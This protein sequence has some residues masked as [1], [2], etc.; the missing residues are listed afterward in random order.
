MLNDDY[1]NS[2]Q[3]RITHLIQLTKTTYEELN[4]ISSPSSY[5]YN[6]KIDELAELIFRIMF[7]KKQLFRIVNA[8]EELEHMPTRE[9]HTKIR[10]QRL[11]TDKAM[12]EEQI[13]IIDS[14]I[15]E[16]GDDKRFDRLI[17]KL[18]MEKFHNQTSLAGV[19]SNLRI[20]EQKPDLT[21]GEIDI[22]LQETEGDITF[23]GIIYLHNTSIDVGTIEYRGDCETKWLG[24]IGYTIS[25]P[26]KGNNYA[27]KALELISPVIASKGVEKVTITVKKHNI[28]SIKTIEKFGGILTNTIDDDVLSYTCEIKPILENKITKR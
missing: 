17:N 25:E 22:Y 14:A 9:E 5:E 15:Q 27:F 4:T 12:F 10:H 2:L 21:D 11:L 3:D 18:E 6:Q 26:H 1:I 7:Y 23:K 13:S 20:F 24:D 19:K 16:I 8:E 28:A